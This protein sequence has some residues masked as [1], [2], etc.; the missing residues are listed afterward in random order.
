MKKIVVI[1]ILFL[2]GCAT[3]SFWTTLSGGQFQDQRLNFE[4]TV[5]QGWVKSE[6]TPYF[7]I[8]KDGIGLNTIIVIRQTV[9]A[10]AEGSQKIFEKNMSP[11]ELAEVE[12]SYLEAD[13]ELLKLQ[14]LRNELAHV[15]GRDSAFL[16]YKYVTADGLEVKGQSYTFLDGRQ[17]YRVKYEAPQQYYFERYYGNFERFIKTFRITPKA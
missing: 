13:K 7:V 12:I 4:A 10:K 17:V 2:S 5:P 11:Q 1:F 9:E 14:C 16:E 6:I 15:D 8:T 3:T